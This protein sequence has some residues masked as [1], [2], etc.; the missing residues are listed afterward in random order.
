MNQ[1]LKNSYNNR[2]LNNNRLNS[3]L[4]EQI[5]MYNYVF[6]YDY[7]SHSCIIISKSLIIDISITFNDQTFSVIITKLHFSESPLL[8]ISSDKINTFLTTNSNTINRNINRFLSNNIISVRIRLKF[9][10]NRNEELN[11]N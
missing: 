5:E 1:V 8:E 9:H 7:L 2:Y 10:S 6:S 3:I 11:M 4:E